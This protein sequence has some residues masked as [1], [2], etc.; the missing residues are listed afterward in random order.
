MPPE[1]ARQIR[2]D[3]LGLRELQM[4]QEQLQEELQVQPDQPSVQDGANTVANLATL[5]SLTSTR[6]VCKCAA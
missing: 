1:G 3:S 5:C 2:L 4:I 6:R